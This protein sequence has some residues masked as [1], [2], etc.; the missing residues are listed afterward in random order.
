[1]TT[2][3]WGIILTVAALIAVVLHT[4]RWRAQRVTALQFGAGMVARAGFVL[5]GLM[6][7]L[8]YVERWPR[9]PV[10][11]LAIVGVGIVLN[12]LAGILAGIQ[13]SRS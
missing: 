13:R 3:V 2:S 7:A 5:L 6:Y 10:V 11:G 8:H 9:A 12:L 4:R 1:M